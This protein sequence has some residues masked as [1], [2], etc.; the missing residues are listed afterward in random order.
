MKRIWLAKN[1]F[2]EIYETYRSV[3]FNHNFIKFDLIYYN[4]FLVM[5]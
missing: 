4:Y 5:E 2:Y 3:G 1:S